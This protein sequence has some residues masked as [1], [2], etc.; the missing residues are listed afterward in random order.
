MIEI[1][2]TAHPERPCT[3]F[4]LNDTFEGTSENYAPRYCNCWANEVVKFS[5]DYAKS[6][7]AE[8]IRYT[9]PF[10]FCKKLVE[11]TKKQIDIPVEVFQ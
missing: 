4:V 2:T 9:G 3:V 10:D 7:G 6:F 5:I 8:R 1:I 11:E